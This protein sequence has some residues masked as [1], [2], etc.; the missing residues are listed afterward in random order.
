MCRT[1][2]S[3]PPWPK[4]SALTDFAGFPPLSGYLAAKEKPLSTV[5]LVSDRDDPILAW[6][7]Y[8]AGRV[9]CW[10]SDVRG[11]WTEA[12]LSWEEGADFLAGQLSF[13]MS[14]RQAEGALSARIKGDTLRISYA[15]PEGASAEGLRT[16]ATVLSPQAR[17]SP[18]CF[19][20]SAPGVFSGEI[21]SGGQGAYAIRVEQ[22][23]ASGTLVRAVEGGAV[24][25]SPPEYDITRPVQARV[26]ERLAEET[27]GRVVTDAAQ[28]LDAPTSGALERRDIS[29]A[30]LFRPA[31]VPGGHRPAQAALGARAPRAP[32]RAGAQGQ[33]P[34]PR[35][36]R[37]KKRR[38]RGAGPKRPHRLRRRRRTPRPSF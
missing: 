14:A 6:W 30:L 13:V 11:G 18:Q 4:E 22:T 2:R 33:R 15:L 37:A 36:R 5:A 8:G 19:P 21:S 16:R 24:S 10:T 31:M 27:G 9:L 25:A 17:R 35:N 32:W 38:P 7:Q 34:G 28:L 29:D 3:R 12:Y 20:E 1:A 26:L 23:D